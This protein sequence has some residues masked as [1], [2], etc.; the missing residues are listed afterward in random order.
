MEGTPDAVATELKQ[1]LEELKGEVGDRKR[2]N[3]QVLRQKSF[4]AVAKG[5][6][7]QRGI[8]DLLEYASGSA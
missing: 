1:V 3:L 2:K 7:T 8:K 4:D 6:E 5:G